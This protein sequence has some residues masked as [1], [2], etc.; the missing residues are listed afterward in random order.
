MV[1]LLA[2]EKRHFLALSVSL[3]PPF[4]LSPYPLLFIDSIT[5]KPRGSAEKPL[6]AKNSTIRY[7]V[8]KDMKNSFTV[9]TTNLKEE[10]LTVAVKM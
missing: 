1:L 5:V 4:S 3:T 9:Y 8:P 7:L 10:T 6:R 2:R